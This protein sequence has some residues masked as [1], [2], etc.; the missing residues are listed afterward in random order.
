[1]DV[2]RDQKNTDN[3][4]NAE[5]HHRPNIAR[6]PIVEAFSEDVGS[7][8]EQVVRLERSHCFEQ[9]QREG[10]VAASGI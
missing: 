6:G 5:D 1:M 8:L 4:Q 3:K 2:D 10:S 9:R 7:L